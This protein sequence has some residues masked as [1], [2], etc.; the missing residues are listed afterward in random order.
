MRTTIALAA[1][2]AGAAFAAGCGSVAAPAPGQPGDPS[3]PA[4]PRPVSAVT[5]SGPTLAG[6]RN[7]ARREARRLMTRAVVPPGATP[8]QTPPPSLPGPAGGTDSATSVVDISQYWQLP[9][10]LPQAT[11]WLAAH[12][13]RGLHRD[14]S[15]SGSRWGVPQSAGYTYTGPQNP[16]WASAELETEV[17]VG[18]SGT[19]DSVLRV[20]ADVVWLDPVPI[21]DDTAGSRLR[22]T[23]AGGCP[24]TDRNDVGVQNSGRDLRTRLLPAAA[25]AAPAAPAAAPAAPEAGIECFYY[26]LNGHP[27]KL[28]KQVVLG[29][30]AA[31]RVSAAI[32]RLPLSH[33]IGGM[34]NCPMDDESMEII[35][36]SYPGR[37]DVD[38]W[39]KLNGCATVA[40]GYIETGFQ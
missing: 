38:L 3:S 11:A 22:V 15:M 36:L 4:R 19:S 9:M 17:G 23:V 35:A 10:T 7:L 6:N 24:A 18:A 29:S 21:P 5:G 40:N 37:P 30:A 32:A 13:P 31:T 12:P 16:A 8:V 28:R 26:G 2:V 39:Q 14:G 20:D 33:V 27:F 1:I 34:L 25:P